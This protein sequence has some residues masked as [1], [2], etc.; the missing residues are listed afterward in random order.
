ML[1][2][3]PRPPRLPRWPAL[4][5]L[6]LLCERWHFQIRYF[7]EEENRALIRVT[8]NW[9]GLWFVGWTSSSWLAQYIEF[10]SVKPIDWWC[11]RALTL[12]WILIKTH[13]LI[14][15]PQVL[16]ILPILENLIFFPHEIL[17][18]FLKFRFWNFLLFFP[19]N[20][21]AKITVHNWFFLSPSLASTQDHG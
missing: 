6:K 13:N 19:L 21:V 16:V 3:Q 18:A 12:Q 1:S 14:I 20:L 5:Q 15:V 10:F 2:R 4:V 17:H 7:P 11:A 8:S 9:V